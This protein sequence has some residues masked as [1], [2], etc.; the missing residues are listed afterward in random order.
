MSQ[1]INHL[2]GVNSS[3]TVWQ[4]A[5]VTNQLVKGANRQDTFPSIYAADTGSAT[6]YVM[7][8]VPGIKFYRVGQHF[9]FKATNANTGA[10]PT[11]NVNGL[12]AGVITKAGGASLV[13]SDIAPNAF[14]EVVVT[15]TTPTFQ[16]IS[17][18]AFTGSGA[19]TF[20]GANVGLTNVTTFF[21]GPNTGSIG[22]NGQTW[23]IMAVAFMSDTAS[24]AALE[25]A[26]FDGTNY[27]AD[28]VE[29]SGGASFG[30]VVTIMKVVSLTGATTFTLRA[31]DLTSTNGLLLTTGNTTGAANVSTSITAV[32]LA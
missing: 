15:S 17:P 12:G 22:A 31:K 30:A 3:T 13:P 18:V 1:T 6:A 23:L 16:L 28:A 32:R 2:P 8:P 26:I 20:L 7:T 25:A 27:I 10:A 9:V 11:L 29:T 24:A 4:H 21:N 5:D 14:V 19:T